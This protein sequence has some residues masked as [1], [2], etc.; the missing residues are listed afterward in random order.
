M[1]F[2]YTLNTIIYSDWSRLITSNINCYIYVYTICLRI[3]K[4]KQT[5]I[6]WI[7]SAIFSC[8]YISCII[9]SPLPHDF[10]SCALVIHFTLEF[11]LL[12]TRYIWMCNRKIQI[13]ILTSRSHLEGNS[14]NKSPPR[15]PLFKISSRWKSPDVKHGIG[16]A[17]IKGR[18]ATLSAHFIA[19]CDTASVAT[20][21]YT[22]LP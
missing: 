8:I 5:K 14:L 11:G 18:C 12:R 2:H 17:A 19:D 3:Y 10:H 15:V 7:S 16:N 1:F 20:W 9:N 6:M 21:M 13:F 22:E 4:N